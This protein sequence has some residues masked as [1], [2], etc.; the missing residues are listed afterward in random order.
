[1]SGVRIPPPLRSEGTEK[2]DNYECRLLYSQ[3][4]ILQYFVVFLSPMGSKMGSTLG[5]SFRVCS[6]KNAGPVF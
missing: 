2:G 6:K 4:K 5:S 3:V 1:M